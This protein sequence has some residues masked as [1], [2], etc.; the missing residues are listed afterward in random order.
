MGND[1]QEQVIK[2]VDN[3]K[4]LV[5]AYVVISHIEKQK[6]WQTISFCNGFCNNF[7]YS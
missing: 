6:K 1:L 7:G 3:T 5:R 2:V 4:A